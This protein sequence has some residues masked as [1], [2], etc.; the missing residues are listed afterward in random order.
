[1]SKP[2]LVLAAVALLVAACME[3]SDR[4]IGPVDA[5]TG[6]PPSDP[7]LRVT[8]A[9]RSDDKIR[10]DGRFQATYTNGQCGVLA[11]LNLEDLRLA[12]QQNPITGKQ[13]ATCGDPR[14]IALIFDDPVDPGASTAGGRANFLN[15][16]HI[17]NLTGTAER[18]AQFNGTCSR[19]VFNPEEFPATSRV[20]VTRLSADSWAVE[21]PAGSVA[22]CV[23]RAALYRMSF[24]LTVTQLP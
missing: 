4:A 16:D 11:T 13:R 22:M 9:D 23:G 10:S 19:L 12:T 24:S 5:G 18:K 7:A 3:Q 15:V 8:F 14:Y 20:T 17:Q 21:A 2:S 1:M 6:P